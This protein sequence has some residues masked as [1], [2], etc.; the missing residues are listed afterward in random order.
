MTHTFPPVS[1]LALSISTLLPNFTI[2]S[3]PRGLQILNVFMILAENNCLGASLISIFIMAY[4]W[5]DKA[6]SPNCF[7]VTW[8]RYVA[9]CQMFDT[10]AL[11][12]Y[13]EPESVKDKLTY[14][15]SRGAVRPSSTPRWIDTSASSRTE[16]SWPS[17][18]A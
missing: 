13:H 14:R 6:T 3:P 9:A 10:T 5:V 11:T 2:L 18:V 15:A 12:C 16:L 4:S 7:S 1:S 8:T 17:P